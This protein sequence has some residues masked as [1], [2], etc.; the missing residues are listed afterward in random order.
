MPESAKVVD[1]CTTSAIKELV[2]PGLL[3]VLAPIVVGAWLGWQ[4]LGGFLAGIIVSGQLMAVLL[5]DA[6][7]A[8]DNAKKVIEDGAYGGK[9]SDAHAAAVTG[10]TVGDPFKDTAGP[11]LNPL[12][13]VM[14]LVGLL[15]VPIIV[16]SAGSLA[17]ILTG[18]VLVVIIAI[19]LVM[20]KRKG[21]A[22]VEVQERV[23]DDQVA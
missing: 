16:R 7:G 5:C 12:I 15:V 13:K 21:E 17:M 3:A 10:D 11:A 8:W 22:Q 18:L 2:A 4:G 20:S 19:A 1:I 23:G 9:G 6:G 14:N